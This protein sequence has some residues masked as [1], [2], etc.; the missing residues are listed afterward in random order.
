M[1]KEITIKITSQSDG[2][3]VVYPMMSEDMTQQDI[4]IAMLSL[5]SEL[6]DRNWSYEHTK[7]AIDAAYELASMK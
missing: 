1:V 6:N 2:G 4:A 5:F 7:D 3:T